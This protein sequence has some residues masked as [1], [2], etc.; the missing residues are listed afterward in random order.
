MPEPIRFHCN[1]GREARCFRTSANGAN[2]E[3]VFEL[4]AEH[5]RIWGKTHLCGI[6]AAISLSSGLRSYPTDGG[7]N[8]TPRDIAY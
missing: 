5:A 1:P 2:D 6:F 8:T 7:G 3:H 4:A